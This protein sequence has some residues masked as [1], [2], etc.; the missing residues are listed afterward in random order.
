MLC[1]SLFFWSRY[2]QDRQAN[3]HQIFS[4][5]GIW[6]A[7]EKLSFWYL[8]FSGVGWRFKK[9]TF[10]SDVPSFTGGGKTRILIKNRKLHDLAG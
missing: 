1:E 4:E 7:I 9:V 5:D 2:L 6:A 8:N 3:L 10:V